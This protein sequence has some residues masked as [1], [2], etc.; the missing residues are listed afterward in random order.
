MHGS[1]LSYSRYW[2]GNSHP[3]GLFDSW[4]AGTTLQLSFSFSLHVGQQPLH[5]RQHAE[6]ELDPKTFE[7]RPYMP[8][9]TVMTTDG[10]LALVADSDA[11]HNRL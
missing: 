4:T 7:R 3:V 5:Q 8:S 10:G 1:K 6:F 9:S 2:A 11:C